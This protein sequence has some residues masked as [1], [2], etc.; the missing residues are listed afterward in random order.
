[1]GV[2]HS[3]SVQDCLPMLCVLYL[4][5]HITRWE[6][7]IFWMSLSL[8]FLVSC[9]RSGLPPEIQNEKD[10]SVMLLVPSGEFLMGTS[11]EEA[12]WLIER[13]ADEQRLLPEM[14]QHKIYLDAFYI[15]QFEITNAQYQAFLDDTGRE[16][17]LHWQDERLNGDDQPVAGVSWEDAS[18]YC[19]WAGKRLPTEAEWEKASRGIDSRLYPWGDVFDIRWCNLALITA[20]GTYSPVYDIT[21]EVDSYPEGA[22]PYGAM[23]MAGNVREW[24]ADRYDP[25]YYQLSPTHNPQGPRR[26][27][28]R[29]IRGG[30][31]YDT[32][33]GLRCTTR[34]HAEPTDLNNRYEGF[35]CAIDAW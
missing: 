14:P 12:S 9:Q 21:V 35:R 20:S 29:V 22:S 26:G 1:M 16:P 33:L 11:P 34:Y 31:W 17:P 8:F 13:G 25:D 3:G 15:D 27:E 2:H 6:F 24:V 18:A 23:N 4:K 5:Y 32:P 7:R 28:Q 19:Q 10:G 30:A